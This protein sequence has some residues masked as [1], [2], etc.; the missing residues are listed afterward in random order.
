MFFFNVQLCGLSHNHTVLFFVALIVDLL[1]LN[2]VDAVGRLEKSSI[3]SL[4]IMLLMLAPF[5]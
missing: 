3:I 2:L 1:L 5:K 4:H